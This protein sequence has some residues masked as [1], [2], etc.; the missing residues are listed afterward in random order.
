MKKVLF[1]LFLIFLLVACGENEVT[2]VQANSNKT[3]IST[4]ELIP[5]HF[6]KIDKTSVKL[7]GN[8]YVSFTKNGLPT[9]E[10][11]KNIA[12]DLIEKNP[13]FE[14]YFFQFHFPFVDENE[15][16]N[17]ENFDLYYN[18]NKLGN[19]DF[20]ITPL[21]DSM[22]LYK[23]TL[24]DFVVGHL[25][26]FP[27]SNVAPIKRGYSIKSVIEKLGNPAMVE[28]KTLKYY[29]L[30]DKNQM[31][32]VLYLDT[33]DE[34]VT[35]VNFASWNIQFT[36]REISDIESYITGTKEY[37]NLTIKELEDIF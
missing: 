11:M 6:V 9:I 3:E 32:G 25:G 29:L 18:I 27:I 12:L 16:R 15:M 20:E 10:E 36:D 13:K 2:K 23:M 4:I 33:K 19:S 35:D 28:D 17:E 30:N 21:Y 1:S 34:I 24:D 14:N 37:E 31:F 5:Y 8:V 26:I 7:Q 22:K